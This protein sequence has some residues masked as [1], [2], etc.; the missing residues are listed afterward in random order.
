VKG[1]EGKRSE[2]E[3]E[4]KVRKGWGK[5]CVMA[6]ESRWT[7]CLRAQVQTSSGFFKP[8]HRV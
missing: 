7:A 6:V 5:E 1:G 2:R 3:E 8:M 4:S